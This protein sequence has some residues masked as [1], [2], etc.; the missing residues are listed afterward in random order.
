MG[1][2]PIRKLV[3]NMA[4]PMMASMLVQ[5][6][7]NIVDSVFVS[8]INE[9]SLTAVSLAFPAQNLMIGLATGTG[10][11]VNA[12]LSRALGA[13]DHKRVSEVAEHGVF[14]AMLGYLA[15]MLFGLFGARAFFS[16]Q[17]SVP[18]I[19]EQ[20]TMYLTICC[21]ASFGLFGE[22]MFERLLQST[23]KTVYSMITQGVGAI[24]NIIFDPIFIFVFDWGI[25][26]AA[27]ATVMG[28]ILGCML[29][30]YLNQ[31]KNPEIRLRLRGFRP[32]WRT[33]GRIY[34]IGLPSVLMV[35]IGSVMTFFMNKILIA[36]TAGKETAATVFGAYF[37]LNSFIF[38]PVFGMNN[39]LVPIVAYNYGAQRRKRMTD[40]IRFGVILACA[41]M[42]V[43]C[44][45]F[46]FFPGQLLSIFDA[47]EQM[48]AIGIPA[49][50]IIGMTF[51]VAGACIVIGAV[52]QSLGKSYYSMATSFLRQLVA[53]LPAAYVLARIG[54][55]VGNQDLVWW[56]FPFAEVFAAVANIIFFRRIYR[57]L[58]SAVPENGNIENA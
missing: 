28:Q 7:Y 31:K 38:M 11:G 18:Y 37:K 30:I 16:A 3:L 49:L 58:I 15:F 12:L 2:M 53:L 43:G 42:S 39:A 33:V 54:M 17:T 47:S 44:L 5:A 14:L 46:E 23:G 50:R 55:S 22:I 40:T 34:E 32:Q 56:S 57:T 1:T 29:G 10:V 9:Q 52:F 26:G 21:G 20:G 41:I 48:L 6:M 36:Y 35:A 51:P 24:I 13:K 27:A 45:I 25:A 8:W 4:L 19:V